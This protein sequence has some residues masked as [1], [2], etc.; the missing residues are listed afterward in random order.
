M[1][2]FVVNIDSLS[3]RFGKTFK[4]GDSVTEFDFQPNTIQVLLFKG[5]VLSDGS[6]PAPVTSQVT[7]GVYRPN[8]ERKKGLKIYQIY[9]DKSHLSKLDY[10]PYLNDDCT[11]YFESK[12]MVDLINEGAHSEFGYFGVVSH[13]L[14]EKVSISKS[15]SIPNIANKSVSEFTP[16]MFEH[17]LWKNTPD[18]LSF[19]RHMPHD[20]IT[21]AENFHPRLSEFFKK[22]MTEIGYNWTPAV[23]QNIF[24]CNYFVA[25]SAI[26]E[27]FVK[28]MLEPAMEV[29]DHMPELNNN[30][31]YP[32]PLPD[33]LRVKFGF[34]HY[35]YHAF[36]CE[37]MF[38][39]YA[40][41]N[42]L[43]CLHY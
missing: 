18:V 39:Y 28:T 26:Y 41:I 14:R 33:H 23:F 40:H 36:I 5:F 31:G 29:M 38:S 9:Y 34:N 20:P 35:P 32:K 10:E 16:E 42:K 6:T 30:S 11:V 17:E 21:F 25:Q 2:K 15:Y 4:K 13:K 43:E 19:Q 12:V 3:G 8:F 1:Q 27:H 22:I 37:R 7:H 24:Y